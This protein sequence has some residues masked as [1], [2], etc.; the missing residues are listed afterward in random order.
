MAV[1]AQDIKLMISGAPIPIELPYPLADRPAGMKWFMAQPDDWLYDWAIAIREAAV[2]QA[3]ASPEVKACRHLPP[4]EGWV[5]RQ[6]LIRQQ[7]EER[8]ALLDAKGDKRLPE[9]DLELRNQQDYLLR[10]VDP[11]NYTRADEIVGNR[12]RKAFENWLMPRLIQDEQGALLF[13]LDNKAEDKER[14]LNIGRDIKELLTNY[15]WQ[16][17]VLI[18]SAKN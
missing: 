2:A 16:A 18:Q 17:I 14:W 4:T 12:A 10:L 6:T 7:T 9:E 13:D 5:R 3:S 1:T 15:F 8:I 11:T